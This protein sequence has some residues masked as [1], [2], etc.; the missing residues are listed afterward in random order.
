[1]Y[2]KT[3][4]FGDYILRAIMILLVLAVILPLLWNIMTSFKTSS[5]IMESPW[6]LPNSLNLENYVNAYETSDMRQNVLNSVITTV[7]SLV[8]LLLFSVP[9]SYAISRHNSKLTKLILAVY[10]G[11]IFIDA[12]YILVPLFMQMQFFGILDTLWGLSLIYAMVR[13]PFTIFLLQG[14]F[15]NIPRD[16][17]ESAT[18]DGSNSFQT[19][20][21]IMIP[22]AK[23]GIFT[24]GLLG[25]IGY[26]NE[27]PIAMTLLQ[28]P[29][30]YTLP[31]GLVNLFEVQRYATDWGALF[32]GLVI[33][34]I[35]TMIIYIFANKKLTTGMNVGGIKG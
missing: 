2:K 33:V 28:S 31:V 29:E 23:P 11:C 24:C 8:L 26:W 27:Y 18:L 12:T 13:F 5:Q 32:A 35:P 9:A 10:M 21:H 19:M 14:F 1:M 25:T 34:I 20:W 6:S 3:I 4:R 15:R 7:S 22:L 30:K 16:F 17:E